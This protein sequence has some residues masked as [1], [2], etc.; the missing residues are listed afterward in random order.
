ML[1]LADGGSESW[2]TRSILPRRSSYTNKTR[3]SLLLLFLPP[4]CTWVARN[5]YR[6]KRL[7]YVIEICKPH[8]RAGLVPSVS[9]DDIRMDR[10][11]LRKSSASRLD[12]RQS[13]L[14]TDVF[15]EFV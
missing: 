5:T 10:P 11:R 13:A 8:G 12:G 15:K 6:N 4:I 2:K 3:V 14:L 9:A 7:I 1:W